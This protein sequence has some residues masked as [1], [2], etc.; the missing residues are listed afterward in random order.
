MAG[1]S[2]GR[3]A[4][5]YASLLSVG[6]GSMFA[7]ATAVHHFYAPDLSLPPAPP[8]PPTAAS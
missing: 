6:L 3:S 5:Q 2:L 1:R 8:A 7:G 4:L